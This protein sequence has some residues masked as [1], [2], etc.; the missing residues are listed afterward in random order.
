MCCYI[1]CEVYPILVAF[2]KRAMSLVEGTTKKNIFRIKTKYE[3][4][5]SF[6]FC[7]PYFIS[8]FGNHQHTYYRPSGMLAFCKR[9]RS[10]LISGIALSAK[11]RNMKYNCVR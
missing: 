8:F 7:L 2:L 1:V 3:A 11:N 9:I 4:I 5:Y 6:R 10:S